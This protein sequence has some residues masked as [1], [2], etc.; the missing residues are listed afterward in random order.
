MDVCENV[1]RCMCTNEM[2][3]CIHVCERVTEKSWCSKKGGLVS[4]HQARQGK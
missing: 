4:E 3:G 2:N 1:A